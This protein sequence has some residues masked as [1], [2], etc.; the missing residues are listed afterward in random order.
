LER[1]PRIKATASGEKLPRWL[2]SIA[3]GRSLTAHLFHVILLGAVAVYAAKDLGRTW[4]PTI[5]GVFAILILWPLVLILVAA[6]I[7]KIRKKA[8]L[9]GPSPEQ[10]FTRGIFR[11]L[12]IFAAALFLLALV[13]LFL[14]A[15]H[16]RD[17][18]GGVNSESR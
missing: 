10:Q 3:A 7:T 5:T 4:P 12:W 2:D 18:A 8:T 13:Q 1:A 16:Q 15:R 11:S 17:P 9:G 6:L 14:Q